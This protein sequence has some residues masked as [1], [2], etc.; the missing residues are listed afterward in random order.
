MVLIVGH[1]NTVPGIVASLCGC[2]VAS[3]DEDEYD[4]RFIVAIDAN[5]SAQVEDV[6]LQSMPLQN[7]PF[8][9]A[10]LEGTPLP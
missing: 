8:E 6:P 3:I 10:P 7:M 9:G 1:S 5:G 4:H 2:E